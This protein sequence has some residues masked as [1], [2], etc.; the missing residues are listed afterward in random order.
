MENVPYGRVAIVEDDA[1]MA[2][3]LEGTLE[4]AGYEIVGM[5]ETVDDAVSL[6]GWQR[7]DLALLDVRLM[8]QRTGVDVAMEVTLRYGTGV[9]FE[10]SESNPTVRRQAESTGPFAWLTKP[11]EPEELL[12][13][14]DAA[15][16]EIHT[17]TRH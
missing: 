5:A 15:M 2:Q 4:D 8:G 6:I 11:F 1:P 10:T 3:F 14:V 12:A 17:R 7:P 9:I 13:A 16:H